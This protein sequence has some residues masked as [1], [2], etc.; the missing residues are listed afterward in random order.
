LSK[1]RAQS[2]S[3]FLE[4]HAI[5]ESRIKTK[6]YGEDQPKYPNDTKENMSKNRRVE[7]AIYAN[8]EMV[9]KAKEQASTSR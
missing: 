2:V 9:D 6:W 5:S 3:D 4:G 1:R 8:E 7:F